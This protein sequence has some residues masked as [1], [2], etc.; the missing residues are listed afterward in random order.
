[1]RVKQIGDPILREV[2]SEIEPE[3]IV[4]ADTRN[5]IN[6]MKRVLD[7]I[8]N[9]SDSNG[10]AIAAPQVGVAIR[11]I[12]LRIDNQFYPMI[13][14]VYSYRSEQTFEFE[15]ECFSFYNLRAMVSRHSTVTVEYYDEHAQ[16]QSKTLSGEYS[17]LAQHE[18]D[19]LD[20]VFFLDRVTDKASLRSVDYLLKD[21]SAHLSKVKEMIDYMVG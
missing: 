3:D 9:I 5:T 17:A 19:H 15:E 8:K 21:N 6:Q 7:G 14:P 11:L 16:L 4:K 18:I 20:G 10:N 12:L 1:M 13:N 2:C